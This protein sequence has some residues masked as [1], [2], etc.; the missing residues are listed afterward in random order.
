MTSLQHD[1]HNK[2]LTL[3]KSDFPS[4]QS[5]SID[6]R[7]NK[8]K[9]KNNNDADA[10]ADAPLLLVSLPKNLD[11]KDLSSSQFFISEEN[12]C[13]L[14][15]ESKGVTFDLIRVES[16]NAYVMF[17]P[18]QSTLNES[19][20]NKSTS[21]NHAEGEGPPSKRMKT[22][23]SETTTKTTTTMEGRLLREKNT[24][25]ME[26]EIPKKTNLY[27]LVY[28]YLHQYCVYTHQST[29]VGKSVLELSERFLYSQREVYDVLKKMH[30]FPIP[31]GTHNGRGNMNMNMNMNMSMVTGGEEQ[32]DVSNTLTKYGVLSEEIE[33]D[34]WDIILS[35]LAEWEG[36]TDYAKKGVNVGEMVKM[37]MKED[38]ENLE[39]GVVN[40]CIKQC[41]V[42]VEE[43]DV[44]SNTGSAIV[45]LDP[46]Y[47]SI[48]KSLSIYLDSLVQHESIFPPQP[49]NFILFFFVLFESL[50]CRLHEN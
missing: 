32:C 40:Y 44:S 4:L 48:D 14:I 37:V 12:G 31:N 2:V 22:A 43:D 3:P 10:D 13:R 45:K 50:F 24:F 7:S 1:L 11:L 36:G 46:N 27:Q 30:A 34:T 5:S 17:P 28:D 15:N 33:R 20:S 25:F 47:V 26:C 29:N 39:E 21:P 9:N 16:S 35:V 18:L 49:R 6:S 42:N 23:D 19:T 41:Q 8:N 38:E